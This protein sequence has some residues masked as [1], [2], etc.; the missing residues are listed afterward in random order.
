M[1]SALVTAH[2]KSFLFVLSS[3]ETNIKRIIAALVALAATPE[4]GRQ[5]ERAGELLIGVISRHARNVLGQT[6]HKD[7]LLSKERADDAGN[8]ARRDAAIAAV[9]AQIV[10]V[11]AVLEAVFGPSVLKSLGVS[12]ATP[13]ET[14]ALARFARAFVNGMAQS[15]L[16]APLVAGVTFDPKSYLT[17]LA[18]AVVELEQAIIE[19]NIDTRE[20]QAALMER[21]R[22]FDASRKSFSHVANFTNALLALADLEELAK[23]VRPTGRAPGTV[24][25][26]PEPEGTESDLPSTGSDPV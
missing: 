14:V 25:D 13:D 4:E 21:D 17:Q 10:P 22:A 16:P 24:A 6:V 26:N 8:A 15:K 2:Q 9:R 19:L 18:R 7:E 1:L 3:L 5:V 23:R 12:G 11:R 20:N